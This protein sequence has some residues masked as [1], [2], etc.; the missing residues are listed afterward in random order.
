MSIAF[1]VAPLPADE[2][3]DPSLEDPSLMSV[4]SGTNAE[5]EA[6]TIDRIMRGIWT[7]LTDQEKKQ[8]GVDGCGWYEGE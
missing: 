6:E 4:A 2:I 7:E 1:V 5:R 3:L 8:V